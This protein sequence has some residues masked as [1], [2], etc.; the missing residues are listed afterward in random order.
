MNY[1]D[2]TGG[3][4]G[5]LPPNKGSLSGGG[6]GL[7]GRTAALSLPSEIP[8]ISKNA[9]VQM[10]SKNVGV[11]VGA[12]LF[13]PICLHVAAATALKVLDDQLGSHRSSRHGG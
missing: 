10:F 6:P 9:S 8:I 11:G 12:F 5:G 13:L 4:G 1:W 2:L 3:L 7:G